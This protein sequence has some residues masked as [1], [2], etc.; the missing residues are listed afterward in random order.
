MNFSLRFIAVL[1]LLSSFYSQHLFAAAP[2]YVF[3]FIGDG[4]GIHQVEATQ[5]F[6]QSTNPVGAKNLF[7]L[8][9]PV[10]TRIQTAS[11][12]SLITCS[13]AAGTA[14]AT[15]VKTHIGI[16]GLGPDTLSQPESLRERAQK[17]KM[18]TGIISSVPLNHATPA[19][20]YARQKSRHDYHAIAK[21]TI[22]SGVD[23]FGG[24]LFLNEEENEISIL[25]LLDS[26]GYKHTNTLS[27]M[28]KLKASDLPVLVS[29]P[30]LDPGQAM[31]LAL[32][33]PK[34]DMDLKDIVAKAIELL[35]NP[36]GFFIMTEGGRIDW[37]GHNNDLGGC[38]HEV[39]AFD[40]A[41]G[42]AMDFYK[43]FPD[44][45]LI[46][47]TADH[48]TGGLTL[49]NNQLPYQLHPELIIQQK[50]SQ[51]GFTVFMDSKR[52]SLKTKKIPFKNFFPVLTKYF[53]LNQVESPLELSSQE[54]QQLEKAYALSV[55]ATPEDWKE[56]NNREPLGY[57]ASKI[58][59]Q[60]AGFHWGS[61]HHTANPVPL[62]AIGKGSEKFEKVRDISQV[63]ETLFKVLSP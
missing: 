27:D 9:S 22:T 12:S 63:G 24:G 34:G 23:F 30:N 36:N 54:Y 53:G 46:V 32:D 42:V 31:P 16:I 56:Y 28:N 44:Q 52:D 60:K 5:Y 1:I 17:R 35:N 55:Y 18:K 38:L 48:E 57:M 15:G 26:A 43:K 59:A 45:T 39:I 49:G 8:E 4:M 47:I 2:K 33:R 3:F 58:L 61:N 29:H 6:L 10:Q 7:M 62:Y 14:L 51:D 37:A 50:I 41:I 19:V 13:A 11:A 25:S 40:K 20:F 21:Q